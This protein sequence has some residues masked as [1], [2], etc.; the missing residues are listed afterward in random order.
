MSGKRIIWADALKG[1]LIVLVVL[2]HSIKVSM[3][4]MDLSFIDDYLWNLIYSFHMPAFMAVSGYLAFRKNGIGG[5]KSEWISFAWRRFRQLIIP[6]LLWSVVMFFVN[7]NVTNFYDYIL[8]PHLS[9]WFL[10]ALFFIAIIFAGIDLIARQLKVKQEFLMAVCWVLLVAL[11]FVMYDAKLL[12]VEYIAY[13]FFYYMCG[14]YVHKYFERLITG[15]NLLIVLSGILWFA[16]GSI[17]NTQGLP[18]ELQFIPV[19]PHSAL[20]M[21]YRMLTAL[22][23]IFFLFSLG[24]KVFD[25]EDGINKLIVRFGTVSLGIYAVHMVLRFRLCDGILMFVPDLSYWSLMIITFCLLLTV[26]YILV[27][28]LGKWSITSVFLLGKLNK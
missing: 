10:W 12:G 24:Q 7:H 6:F 28:L 9:L 19:I 20:Y 18:R 2:G 16:L 8:Y 1:I 23:A 22:I 3:I 11:M 27:W 25:H 5:G 21:A 26:S 15:N 4:K 13:Y 14:Y 17:Y